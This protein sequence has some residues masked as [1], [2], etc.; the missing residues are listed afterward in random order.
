MSKKTVQIDMKDAKIP[1]RRHNIELPMSPCATPSQIFLEESQCSTQEQGWNNRGKQL[2]NTGNLIYK[3]LSPV[4]DSSSLEYNMKDDSCSSKDRFSVYQYSDAWS[5]AKCYP[6]QQNPREGIA[7]DLSF[8]NKELQPAFLVPNEL[9]LVNEPML[10]HADEEEIVSECRNLTEHSKGRLLQN[11]LMNNAS[12]QDICDHLNNSKEKDPITFAEEDMFPVTK[13]TTAQVSTMNQNM[14]F[15]SREFPL[16]QCFNPEN[17]QLLTTYIGQEKRI[18]EHTGPAE[19]YFEMENSCKT[20]DIYDTSFINTKS[21]VP[22]R[23]NGIIFT[24]TENN[25]FNDSIQ[26]HHFSENNLRDQQLLESDLEEFNIQE[27]NCFFRGFE[28]MCN[29]WDNRRTGV[30]YEEHQKK[31]N[32]GNVKQL[33]IDTFNCDHNE[34]SCASSQELTFSEVSASKKRR[35]TSDEI[36]ITKKLLDNSFGSSQSTSDSPEETESCCSA[37]SDMV[38]MEMS[39]MYQPQKRHP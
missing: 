25:F 39:F 8:D 19:N 13:K 24:Q 36:F 23:K 16:S 29:S 5:T 4:M 37:V 15:F 22:L 32:T 3:E 14:A 7:W 1:M 10:N 27:N 20:R 38:V 35:N 12:L 11:S 28:E 30:T 18:C 31:S 33:N 17:T 2:A 26:K 21:D 9:P 34:T 6:L